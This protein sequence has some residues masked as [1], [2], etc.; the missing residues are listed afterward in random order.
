MVTTG[1]PAKVPA[2]CGM[3]GC[4]ATFTKSTWP[5]S[6]S[7]T[8]SYA[9]ALTPPEVI[10]RSASRQS[11]FER[12]VEGIDVIGDEVQPLGARAGLL[13]GGG[14]HDPVRLVDLARLHGCA[15]LDEFRPGRE[16][17]HP[18]R[19]M[20]GDHRQAERGQ[21]RE[22]GRAEHGAG[23][24]RGLAGRDVLAG[25]PHVRAGRNT[26]I[27]PD[28]GRP[29]VGRLHGHNRVGAAG[30]RAPVMMRWTV[31]GS[32][33]GT[34]VRPAGMSAATGSVTGAVATSAARTAYPSIAELSKPGSGRGA[35]TSPANTRPSASASGID[36]AAGFVISPDTTAWCS[37]TVRTRT[38]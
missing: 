23:R 25:A 5:A 37:A 19:G 10:S 9:P 33:G 27:D 13:H 11:R 16:H 15:R 8:T 12:G 20:H 17:Q 3:P 6:A 31:P 26:L 14:E 28:G 29:G 38:S 7:L 2:P 21:Q 22:L 34:S 36:C 35:T 4:I 1:S 18:Q 24:Q 30:N 32:S